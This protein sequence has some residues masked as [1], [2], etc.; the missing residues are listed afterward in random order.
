MSL[1]NIKL[2]VF[3][4]FL[5]FKGL[6]HIRTNGG[7]EIWARKDLTRPVVIQTHE[8]PVPEHIIKNN[9]RTIKSNRQE[10][11][12]WLNPYPSKD[13]SVGKGKDETNMDD[14]M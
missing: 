6:K 7:H 2:S 12:A 8:D 14:S 1:K 10:F 4:Q 11:E 5:L 13:I 9:L 3:R